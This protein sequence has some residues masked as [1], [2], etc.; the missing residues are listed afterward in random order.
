GHRPYP[1]PDRPWAGVMRWESLLFIHWAVDADLIVPTLPRDIE[2]DTFEGRAWI[3]IVP[4]LM[5]NTHPRFVPPLPG[6]SRF[7]ELNVRTYVTVDG[8]PGVWFYSLDAASKLAVRGARWLFHLPYFD[9]RM[10]FQRDAD[11]WIHYTS[12][13][14]HRGAKPAELDMVYRPTGEAY[15]SPANELD[16]FLTDRF[17]LYSADQQGNLYRG[18]IH[19]L[20]WPLQPVEARIYKN[21]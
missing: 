15:P 18:Q 11:G 10:S 3:G 20:P 4:F 17:C 14:T 9:A 1:L 8:V 7:L 5:T 21:T 19:H 13:R 6:I 12:T 2:L 16:H